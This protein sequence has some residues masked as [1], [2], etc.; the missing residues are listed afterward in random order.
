MSHLRQSGARD[1]GSRVKLT[2]VTGRVAR[3]VMTRR[4]V[5]RLVFGIERSLFYATLTRDKN[6]RFDIDLRPLLHLQQSRATKSQVWHR[7]MAKC[8]AT[9]CTHAVKIS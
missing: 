8:N 1:K 4:T 9:R 6:C 5:A 7:S 3:C 2:G